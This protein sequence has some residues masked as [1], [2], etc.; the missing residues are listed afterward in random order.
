MFCVRICE[1]RLKQGTGVG[2]VSVHGD[3]ALVAAGDCVIHIQS[4]KN[5]SVESCATA[6]LSFFW[7]SPSRC[8][9]SASPHLPQLS[10]TSKGRLTHQV[11]QRT[12]TTKFGSVPLLTVGQHGG[13]SRLCRASRLTSRMLIRLTSQRLDGR[14]EVSSNNEAI[15]TSEILDGSQQISVL[16]RVVYRWN[17]RRF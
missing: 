2:S 17:G 14:F 4:Q 8:Q 10:A 7:A 11:P 5:V 13:W 16:G 9:P 12:W 15:K 6:I 3:A 1:S